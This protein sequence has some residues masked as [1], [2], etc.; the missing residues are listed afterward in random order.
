LVIEITATKEKHD[1]A[2][3][4]ELKRQYDLIKDAVVRGD[5]ADAVA[6]Q[7]VFRRLAYVSSDLI[8]DHAERLSKLVKDEVDQALGIPAQHAASGVT[9]IREFEELALYASE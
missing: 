4:S 9:R 3:L 8:R 7:Q 6:G 5:V 1:W 2:K